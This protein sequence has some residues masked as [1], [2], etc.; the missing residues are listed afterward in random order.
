MSG[1]LTFAAHRGDGAALLCFDVDE[2]L[3]ADLAG[4]AIECRPPG[5]DPY[6]VLN[7]LGFA[8]EITAETKPEDREW[9]PSSEAPI[10]KFHWIHYPKDVPPGTF[11]Y[12]APPCCSSR[13]P[14][15]S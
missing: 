13:A 10:Q 4:F 12:K 8:Q 2:E 14:K 11:T 6:P 5:G 3:V 9:T 1:G 15:P 7:R